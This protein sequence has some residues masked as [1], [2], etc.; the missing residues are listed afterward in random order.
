[1]LG[2]SFLDGALG[3]PQL[4]YTARMTD[5]QTTAFLAALAVHG[6]T[7][8]PAARAA[9][10]PPSAVY[11]RI[12]SDADFAAAVEDAQAEVY[13]EAERELMRRA[14]DGVNKPVVYK[15]QIMFRTEQA[16]NGDGETIWR[17]VTDQNGQPVPLTINEKSDALLMFA[18]KGYRKKR[19]AERTELTG[20]DGKD[21]ET[22]DETVRAARI[23][24]LL[25][26]AAKR[27]TDAAG[28]EYA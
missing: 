6:G 26:V 27:R 19:F 1:M 14:V 7:L 16:V 10:M 25:D 11:Q 8:A 28:S 15:G 5:A 22:V 13:D 4:R 18:L 23:A 9:G 17:V 12:K 20:A 2:L 3:Q 24:A 21:L